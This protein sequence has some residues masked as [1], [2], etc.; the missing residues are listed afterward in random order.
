VVSRVTLFSLLL[1]A[2]LGLGIWM[3]TS[4]H[5]DGCSAY[6]DGNKSA[7]SS[8]YVASGSQLMA[9]P[10]DVW[11]MRQSPRV[12]LLCLVDLC[13]AVV[14]VLNALGNLQD[15]FALRRQMRDRH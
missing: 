1:G 10:C 7:Q 8:E 13:M 2:M 14:F 6:L 9:V 4:G 5:R 11:I 15:W 12:Q 3:G